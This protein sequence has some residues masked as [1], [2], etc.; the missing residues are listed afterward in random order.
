MT[1]KSGM[2]DDIGLAL[3]GIV[4]VSAEEKSESEAGVIAEI[5]GP[6][7]RAHYRRPVDD[8]LVEEARR[9]PGY[10]V[11]IVEVET[12]EPPKTEPESD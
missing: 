4:L 10:S 3:Y 7:G 8:A 6:S 11:R 9:T 2:A 12:I 5:I 1:G